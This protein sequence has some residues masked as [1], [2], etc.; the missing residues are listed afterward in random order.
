MTRFN[1]RQLSLQFILY[2]LYLCKASRY[3]AEIEARTGRAKLFQLSLEQMLL[4]TAECAYSFPP[5]CLDYLN[6]KF[7]T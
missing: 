4:N 1:M 2:T 6:L 5:A 3:T 7:P